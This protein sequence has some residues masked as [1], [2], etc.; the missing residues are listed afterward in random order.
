MIRSFPDIDS[1]EIRRR[2]GLDDVHVW[3]YDSDEAE[4]RDVKDVGDVEVG[5]QVD[6]RHV[7]EV[8]V[9]VRSMECDQCHFNS[10]MCKLITIS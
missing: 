3:F 1:G 4:R 5:E 6:L 2:I 10:Q 8:F 7:A 9:H